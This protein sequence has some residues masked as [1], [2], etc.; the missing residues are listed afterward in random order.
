MLPRHPRCFYAWCLPGLPKQIIIFQNLRF[1]IIVKLP[2]VTVR[3]VA[4]VTTSGHVEFLPAVKMFPA[5]NAF[6]YLVSLHTLSPRLLKFYTF[7][8]IAIK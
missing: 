7:S 3:D 8:S 2:N 5:N 1:V 6:I 4:I